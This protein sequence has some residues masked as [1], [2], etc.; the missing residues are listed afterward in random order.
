MSK[1]KDTDL[2]LFREAMR[3]VRRL[4]SAKHTLQKPK[5]APKARFMRADQREVLRESL[6]PVSDPAL[7][8]TGDELSFKRDGIPDT[9]LKKLRRGEYVVDAEL[10]LHGM[11][12]ADARSALKDFLLNALSSHMRCIRIVHGKGRRS[13]PRGPV[14]KNLVNRWLRQIDAVVAFGSARP[15]DGGS[16]AVYVLLRS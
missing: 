8:E 1:S 3:D 10:D 5:P 9:V 14:L 6:L 15:N 2:E 7:L 11:N 13:G 12:A 4:S 16:G